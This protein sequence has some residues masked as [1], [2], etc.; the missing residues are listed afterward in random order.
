MSSTAPTPD[1]LSTAMPGAV[2]LLLAAGAGLA[3]AALYYSQPM[4]GVLAVEFNA[5]PSA[6]GLV[7]TLTQ[8]GYA[9]GLVLLAPLGCIRMA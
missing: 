1:Q 7:P 6:I 4:L 8:L 9:L 5:T 2:V 3:A